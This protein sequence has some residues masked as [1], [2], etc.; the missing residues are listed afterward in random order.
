MGCSCHVNPP[1]SYCVEKEEC[2]N[3]GELVH[4]DDAEYIQTAVD[5]EGGPFCEN[6]MKKR[7]EVN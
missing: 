5:A 6:C 1:C 3:C 4:P 2:L 7:E